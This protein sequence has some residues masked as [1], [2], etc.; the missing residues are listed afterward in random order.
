MWQVQVSQTGREALLHT[1]NSAHVFSLAYLVARPFVWLNRPHTSQQVRSLLDRQKRQ[2]P[3]SPCA[4]PYR[5][6]AHHRL[7][8]RAFPAPRSVIRVENANTPEI[9][10]RLVKPQPTYC[11]SSRYSMLAH[12]TW[13]LGLSANRDQ[14]GLPWR[15]SRREGQ[16]HRDDLRH[17]T[18]ETRSIQAVYLDKLQFPGGSSRRIWRG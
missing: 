16:R 9:P 6:D 13:R 2:C 1:Q 14:G 15:G 5:Q 8:R 17:G 10:S 11:P 12:L 3:P 18:R 4:C 7:R